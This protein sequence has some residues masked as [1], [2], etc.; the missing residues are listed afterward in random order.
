MNKI[1]FE[2]EV[3]SASKNQYYKKNWRVNCFRIGR[4]SCY[5]RIKKHLL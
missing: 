2:L 3:Y 4:T 1:N 5:R